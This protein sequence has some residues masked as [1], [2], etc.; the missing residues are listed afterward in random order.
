MLTMTS[1]GGHPDRANEDFVGAV[2][3]ALVLVD[4]QGITGIEELCR[5]GIAWYAHR[6]G[7]TLLARLSLADAGGTR[8]DLRG[9]LAAAIDEVTDAH[10]DS[11][12]VSDPSSPCGTVAVL[13]VAQ[14]WAD[15]LLLGDSV[16][17]LDVVDGPPEVVEDRR[18]PTT[19]RPF[20]T[21]LAGLT[22]GTPEHE[23]VLDEARTVFRSRRN[24]PGGFW[25]AKDDGAAAAAQALTGSRPLTELAGGV[26]L[27]N[28]ASRVVDRFGLLDWAQLPSRH[29]A[30]LVRMVREA[31]QGEDV[32]ADDATAVCWRW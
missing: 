27:S 1:D 18:E 25:V 20:Q 16:I 21:A 10:R 3:G 2:P 28:G 13:R 24:R 19:A 12:H 4:G 11:C 15:H 5:H 8:P 6:L 30:E 31:E 22:P 14:G 7:T 29:P 26:V 23:R 32:A 17:V 9:V